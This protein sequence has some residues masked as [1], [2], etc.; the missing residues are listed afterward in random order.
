MTLVPGVGSYINK[1]NGD[2]K[3]RKRYNTDMP[4]SI[5]HISHTQEPVSCNGF[6]VGISS[7]KSYSLSEY[8]VIFSIL[9][10]HLTADKK[11]ALLGQT[12]T[13]A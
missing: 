12:V 11:T 10:T 7:R 4:F 13:S 8:W 2:T 1:H 9:D 5:T 6:I 3:N